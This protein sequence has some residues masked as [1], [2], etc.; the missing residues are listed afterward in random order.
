QGLMAT[1]TRILLPTPGLQPVADMHYQRPSPLS[2]LEAAAGEGRQILLPSPRR[3]L[4]C[5]ATDSR[6][7]YF[8]PGSTS[9]NV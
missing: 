9:R 2:I 8:S 4:M 3:T 6:Y 1:E 7:L 5:A